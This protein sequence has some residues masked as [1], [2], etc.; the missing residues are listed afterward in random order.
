[1]NLYMYDNTVSLFIL[2]TFN[3]LSKSTHSSY[4]GYVLILMTINME[5]ECMYIYI[6]IYIIPMINNLLIELIVWKNNY[7]GN[8]IYN[9]GVNY[10]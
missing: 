4:L 7:T 1:M 9:G 5:Y 10:F 6:Y 2:I 8:L 3:T